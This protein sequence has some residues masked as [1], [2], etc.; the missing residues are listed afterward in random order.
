MLIVGVAQS[1]SATPRTAARQASL[2]FIISWSLLKPISIESVMP[3]NH[4]IL[5]RILLLPSTL[6]S[7][8]VFSDESALHI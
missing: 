5:C 8:R 3:S 7:I 1:L 6:P 4:L 2:P